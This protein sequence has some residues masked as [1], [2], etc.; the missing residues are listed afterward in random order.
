MKMFV[1]LSDKMLGSCIGK[2]DLILS[3][4]TCVEW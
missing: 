1:K 3:I 4:L 2:N